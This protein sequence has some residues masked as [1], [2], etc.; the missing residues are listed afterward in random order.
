M[1]H[2]EVRRGLALVAGVVAIMFGP[3]LFVSIRPSSLTEWAVFLIAMG[4][5]MS[6]SLL[7]AAW[8]MKIGPFSD[9][10]ESED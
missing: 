2:L 4:A 1:R 7:Y 5:V 8:R 6:V 3:A 10:A 9:A